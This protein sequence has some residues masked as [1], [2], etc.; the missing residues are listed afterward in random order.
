MNKIKSQIKKPERVQ[1]DD[2]EY[3]FDSHVA[4]LSDPSSRIDPDKKALQDQLDAAEKKVK[5]IEEVQKSLPVYQY[6]D[7]LLK[8]ME[9]HQTLIVVGET[10]SGKSTQIPRYV[11]EHGFAGKGKG[12]VVVTQPRRVAAMSVASRVAEEMGVRLGKE[13]GYSVRFDDKSDL[14]RTNIKFAT[15]GILLREIFGDPML[16]R[17]SV[18][19]I[20]EAHERSIASDILL[21]LT[22]NLARARP[23]LRILIL[24]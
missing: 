18:I 20:D 7:V 3:V 23:E 15:D 21:A 13:V 12:A 11:L 5:T 14:E 2:Y 24:R 10:G 16:S 1:E 8:A 6:R 4:F 19:M 9:E 22:K 17:Y